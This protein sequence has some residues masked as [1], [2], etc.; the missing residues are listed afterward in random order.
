MH[1]WKWAFMLSCG[2]CQ[3][4]GNWEHGDAEKNE[5]KFIREYKIGLGGTYSELCSEE[6]VGCHKLTNE[7]N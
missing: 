5:K 6:I 2:A 3:Y 7:N 4:S 1:V